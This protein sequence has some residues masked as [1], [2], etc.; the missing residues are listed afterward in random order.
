MTTQTAESFGESA[1]LQGLRW[2]LDFIDDNTDEG[3][4]TGYGDDGDLFA[5][6]YRAACEAVAK[7]EKYPVAPCDGPGEPR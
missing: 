2:A 1:L 4:R 3:E 5:R 7:A 6:H